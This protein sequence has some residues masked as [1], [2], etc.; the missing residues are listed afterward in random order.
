[1]EIRYLAPSSLAVE[2]PAATMLAVTIPEVAMREEETAAAEDVTDMPA[3]NIE[4]NGQKITVE[5]DATV[6]ILPNGA[7]E[8]TAWPEVKPDMS[9]GDYNSQMAEIIKRWELRHGE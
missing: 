6:R 2:T 4:V 9:L 5:G 3:L 7:V 1:M 8:V